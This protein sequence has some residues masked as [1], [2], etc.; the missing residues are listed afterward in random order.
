MQ[1]II[2]KKCGYDGEIIWDKTKPDGTPKKLLDI[3]RIKSL[4]WEPKTS[5]DEGLNMAITN[6][7]YLKSK[8]LLRL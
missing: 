3:S 2:S 5:F 6:Y 4:G 7:R 8:N 1:K